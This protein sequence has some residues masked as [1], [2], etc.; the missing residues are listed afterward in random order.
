MKRLTDGLKDNLGFYLGYPATSEK[1]IEITVDL[2]QAERVGRV[3]V[4]AYT[5]HSSFEKYTL[6]VSGDGKSFTDVASRL[7]KPE[8]PE[9][10]VEHKFKPPYRARYLSLIHI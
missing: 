5:L 8:S 2:E 6:Q 9:P 10:M 4:H 3:V 1:P 7:E